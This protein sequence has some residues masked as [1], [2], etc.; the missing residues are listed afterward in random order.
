MKTTVQYDDI[1]EFEFKPG[2]T[3][4][5][6]LQLTQDDVKSYFLSGLSLVD[7]DCPACLSD[8]RSE[9]FSKFGLK[10]QECSNCKTLYVSPRPDEKAIDE[11]YRKSN[12]REFW[13]QHLLT[14]TEAKRREKLFKPRVQWIIET[15]EEYFPSAQ[16]FSSIN[17][18]H[19]PFLQELIENEFF[20]EI[21]IV[22]PRVDLSHVSYEKTG[23]QVVEDSIGS[24]SDK[25]DA[26]TLFVVIDRLSDVDAFVGALE[27]VLVTGGLCFLTTISISGF[28]LQVLWDKSNSIFPPDRMNVLSTE[29]LMTLFERHGFE[30]IELSTPGLLDVQIVANAYKENASIEIP[31][32]VRYLIDQ[33]DSDTLQAFQEFL[34]MNRLSS[35][36]RAVF[37]KK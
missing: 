35:F 8:E 24:L 13:N 20:K 2:T 36:T 26:V 21:R 11:Y 18:I 33:R 28:D 23:V 6:Y 16:R 7:C 15:I 31:R 37:Q 12:A 3:L 4:T 30:C 17:S 27:R 22:T 9:A 19:P 25:A 10:Y 34:Q 14:E 1:R 32:F 29:G 5:T